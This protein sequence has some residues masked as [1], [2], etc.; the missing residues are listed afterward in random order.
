MDVALTVAGAAC[1]GM[2]FGHEG[3]GRWVLP[4]LDEG[5]VDATPVGASATTVGMIRVTWHVVTLFVAMLG[6]VLLVL[7]TSS[8][9]D[10]RAMLLRAI[11]VTWIV[12]TLMAVAVTQPRR[13]WRSFLRL[14]VPLVWVLVAVL[15]WVA[16]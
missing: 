2:A 6:V 10:V 11:A 13:N 16:A 5:R 7:A 1:V 4:R 9:V 15:C 8:S 12:A 14:P 3:V